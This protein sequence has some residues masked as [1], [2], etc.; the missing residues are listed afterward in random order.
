M[1][2]FLGIFAQSPSW[3]LLLNKT[4]DDGGLPQSPHTRGPM[5]DG[6]FL[7]ITS[8]SFMIQMLGREA[9]VKVFNFLLFDF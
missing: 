6:L 7:M 5:Y 8:H 3:E 2:R 9:K 1:D 4:Y